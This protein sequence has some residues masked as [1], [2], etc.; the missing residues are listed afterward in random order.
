MLHT[1][2][3]HAMVI[4]PEVEKSKAHQPL[5][6]VSSPMLKLNTRP[7]LPRLQVESRRLP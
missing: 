3:Y 5:P 6:I 2:M 7:L 4:L 1:A